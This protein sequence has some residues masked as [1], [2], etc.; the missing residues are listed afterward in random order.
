MQSVAAGIK[1]GGTLP[2]AKLDSS[3]YE[4][5]VESERRFNLDNKPIVSN[6]KLKNIVD[7]LYKGQNG[8]NKIGNGTTMDAVRNEIMTGEATHGKFHTK[9]LEDYLNA[10][11]RRLRA[12]DL[13]SHDKIVAKTLIEDINEI[14]NK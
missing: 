13:S 9:K 10:L 5:R 6:Q 3:D 2:P 12:G 7:D 1:Q 4:W 8:P 14:F 11:E